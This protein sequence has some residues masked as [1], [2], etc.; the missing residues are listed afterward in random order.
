MYLDLNLVDPKLL[1][2]TDQLTQAFWERSMRN[3]LGSGTCQRMIRGM[4]AD[5][6]LRPLLEVSENGATSY[7]NALILKALGFLKSHEMKVHSGSLQGDTLQFICLTESGWACLKS[8]KDRSEQELAA[9]ELSRK[10]FELL[11][12]F[13]RS[14]LA[15]DRGSGIAISK[16]VAEFAL[17]LH[18]ERVLGRMIFLEHDK[19][20]FWLEWDSVKLTESEWLLGEREWSDSSRNDRTGAQIIDLF[21]V[22][23]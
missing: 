7:E 22:W 13:V 6:V 14:Y 21:E 20:Q 15:I 3:E 2:K 11:T 1:L 16:K 10:P 5:P 4:L 12:K 9:H 18:D 19:L 23:Q 17:K 8:W